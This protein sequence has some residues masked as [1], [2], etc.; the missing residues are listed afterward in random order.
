MVSKLTSI[1]A[2]DTVTS[3]SAPQITSTNTAGAKEINRSLKI[4]VIVHPRNIPRACYKCKIISTNL[5]TYESFIIRWMTNKIIQ[6]RDYF[7]AMGLF[8]QTKLYSALCIDQCSPQA[9][10]Q[11][12]QDIFVYSDI[13][14][15]YSG[16]CIDLENI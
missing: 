13:S 12:T 14:M 4:S 6:Q 1:N 9:F 10:L 16:I 11:C 2:E 7:V 8:H 3:G 15:V 5:H